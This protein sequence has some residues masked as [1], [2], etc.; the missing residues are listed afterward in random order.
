MTSYAKAEELK[1]K[2]RK[3]RG[4]YGGIYASHIRGEGKELVQINRSDYTGERG[5]CLSR[6]SS[7]AAYQPGTRTGYD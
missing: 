3:S 6:L 2:W 4:N 5:G 7:Q 1:S